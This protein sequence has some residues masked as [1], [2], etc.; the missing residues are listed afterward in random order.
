MARRFA[1]F[2]A[3]IASLGLGR[4]NG[5]REGP[6]VKQFSRC[7]IPPMLEAA[8]RIFLICRLGH[9]CRCKIEEGITC[10]PHL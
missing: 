5:S 7:D 9:I 1:R 3:N 8:E 6:I 4:T 2:S 10:D